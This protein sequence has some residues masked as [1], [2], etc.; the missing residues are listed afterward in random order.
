MQVQEIENFFDQKKIKEYKKLVLNPLA[1]KAGLIKDLPLASL[2][3]VSLTKLDDNNCEL[4]V[5]Y[6]F[7]NKNPFNTTYWAVLGMVAEMGSGALLLMYTNKLKP[8]VSTFVIGC[9]AKF[10]KTAVG[11][12]TFKCNQGYEIA[13]KVMKTCQTFEA[14]EIVCQTNAYNEKGEVVAEF[15]FTWGIKARKPKV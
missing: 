9:E 6:R 15:T 11:L 3:G 10:I 4:T 5:P 8:S 7:L 1:F 12:T 14:Q 13:S 2:I